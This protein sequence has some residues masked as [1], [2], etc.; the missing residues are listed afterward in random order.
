M[1]ICL[2]ANSS[3]QGPLHSKHRADWP[4]SHVGRSLRIHGPTRVSPDGRDLNPPWRIGSNNLSESLMASPSVCR[5]TLHVAWAEDRALLGNNPSA[6]PGAKIGDR[7][8]SSSSHFSPR[9]APKR[10]VPGSG[11]EPQ[12]DT[13]S[14]LLPRVFIRLRVLGTQRTFFVS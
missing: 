4:G 10:Q 5:A 6:V 14:S 7:G 9:L 2:S 13:C 3:P 1:L 11:E 8:D 12:Q